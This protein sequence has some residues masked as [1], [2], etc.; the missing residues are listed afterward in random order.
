MMIPDQ[1]LRLFPEQV[2]VVPGVLLRLVRNG[3]GLGL[4]VGQNGVRLGLGIGHQALRPGLGVGQL[5]PGLL[6]VG[7]RRL[8]I[9]VRRRL[10]GLHH[11]VDLQGRLGD[12]PGL[13][14]AQG[15]V[16]Q[17]GLQPGDLLP[18]LLLALFQ[19]VYD[20]D[21]L[22]TAQPSEFLIRHR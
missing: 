14:Q 6:P 10:G 9:L 7:F 15:P 16:L 20:L 11:A 19:L 21:Q 1:L 5:R 3:P 4:G 2:P 13:R 17:P 8:D 22:R 18:A 12:G